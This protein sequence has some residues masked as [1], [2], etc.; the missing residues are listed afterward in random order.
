MD[1]GDKTIM[2]E[3]LKKVGEFTEILDLKPVP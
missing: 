2:Y 3:I 1:I